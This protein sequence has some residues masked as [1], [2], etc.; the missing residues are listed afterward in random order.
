MYILHVYQHYLKYK[1][2]TV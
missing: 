1:L 2:S